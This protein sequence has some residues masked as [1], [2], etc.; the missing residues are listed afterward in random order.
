MTG[1]RSGAGLRRERA[2]DEDD[3]DRDHIGKRANAMSRLDVLTRRCRA[4]EAPRAGFFV[5]GL[6][7]IRYSRRAALG[8]LSYTLVSATTAAFERNLLEG[9]FLTLDGQPPTRRVEVEAEVQLPDH[10]RRDANRRGPRVLWRR[11][12]QLLCA[13]RRHRSEAVGSEDRRR[14]RRRG[15]HL[16][17]ER[18]AESRSGDRLRF[19]RLSGS[20]PE[21]AD[22]YPRSRGRL[23]QPTAAPTV[24]RPAKSPDDQASVKDLNSRRRVGHGWTGP[25]T[26]L[27]NPTWHGQA[28]LRWQRSSI[29][30]SR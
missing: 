14:D 3:A 15:D 2:S 19:P 17:S 12:R 11:E 23:K 18:R 7:I 22:R 26:T 13:R 1:E 20:N 21:S 24:T 25:R 4:V 27:R 5:G 30:R 6:E 8:V 29:G 28:A 10:R 9:S 16:Y